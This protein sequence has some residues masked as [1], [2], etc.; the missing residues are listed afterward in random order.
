MIHNFVL[1]RIPWVDRDTMMK[2]IERLQKEN[3][4]LQH[5]LEELSKKESEETKEVGAMSDG[6][7]TY[8]VLN[9]FNNIEMRPDN[10]KEVSKYKSIY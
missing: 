1:I 7:P 9:L 8:Q 6:V 3:M 4:I 10:S 5:K 2:K